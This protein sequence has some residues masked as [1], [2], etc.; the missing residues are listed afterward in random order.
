MKRDN[1]TQLCKHT[2]SNNTREVEKLLDISSRDLK[3]E[4]NH[5]DENGLTPL[6]L[7]CLNG[8]YALCLLLLKNEADC[9]SANSQGQT[10]LM[11]CA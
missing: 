4:I 8:N 10:S 1:N 5:R 9:D 11:L 7:S 2:R 3:P 6:H